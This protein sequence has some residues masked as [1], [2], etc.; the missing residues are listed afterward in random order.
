MIWRIIWQ[1][2]KRFRPFQTM[3]KSWNSY[4]KVWKGRI[5]NNLLTFGTF[6]SFRY[7]SSSFANDIASVIFISFFC[8]KS[9]SWSALNLYWC[10]MKLLTDFFVIMLEII[11]MTFP[12][13]FRPNYWNTVTYEILIAPNIVSKLKDIFHFRWSIIMSY[14]YRSE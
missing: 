11:D 2:K 5:W 7:D 8:S 1:V 14:Q 4:F 9:E 12:I 10:W 13:D 3:M 6:E